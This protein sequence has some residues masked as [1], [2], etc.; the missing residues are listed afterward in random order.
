MHGNVR[1]WTEDCWNP[2]L[3]GLP[4][5][6]SARTSGDCTSHVVRG[7]AWSDEPRDLRS[8]KRFWERTAER[9]AQV[10]LRV[11]RSCGNADAHTTGKCD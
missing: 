2:N 1:E 7:G 10:G 5:D 4:R 6:G 8:A 11:A 9:K 3:S